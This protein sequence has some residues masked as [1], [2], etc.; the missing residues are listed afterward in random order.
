VRAVVVVNPNATSTRR[1]TRDVLLSALAGA[2]DVTIVTTTHRD[3]AAEIAAQARADGVDAVIAYGGD[4]TVNEVVNG[5][6][7]AGTGP[8]VP[9]L[10]VVPGG[11]ANVFARNLGLPN[12]ALESAG[13]LIRAMADPVRTRSIG[14]GVANERWFTF[15]TGLGYDA[16]TVL[17]VENARHRGKRATPGL[18]V[19]SAVRTYFRQ[20]RRTPLVSGELPDGEVLPELFL[21]IVTN[22]SPWT[23][24]G[25]IK[26]RTAP[27]SSFEAGLDLVGT[28]SFG[29]AT[30]LKHATEIIVGRQGPRGHDVVHR[31]DLPWVTLN[32]QRPLPVQVDGDSL[33]KSTR[34][35][36]RSVPDALR[37]LV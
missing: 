10:G 31:H 15:N 11:S 21:A 13:R 9:L 35:K 36:C 4:G 30:T 23:Y 28:T 25:R 20:E 24:L 33:G 1:R 22:S 34:L 17:A 32:S 26:I 16:D 37:V 27:K 3:H 14:L 19:R 7:E 5:L 18:Y 29:V 6:L 8:D 12:D 2:A